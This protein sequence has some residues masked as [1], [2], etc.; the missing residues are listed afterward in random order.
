M[1][2]CRAVIRV[3]IE[4]PDQQPIVN[5]LDYLKE[6]LKNLYEIIDVHIEKAI[7]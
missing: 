5:T 2:K 4:V 6:S 1:A 3:E 7:E